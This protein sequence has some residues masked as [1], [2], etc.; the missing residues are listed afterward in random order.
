MSLFDPEFK[1]IS[2]KITYNKYGN[3]VSIIGG[4]QMY[5]QLRYDKQNR[6]SDYLYYFEPVGAVVVWHT[7]TYQPGNKI[8]DT[9]YSYTSSFVTD[10]IR[11]ESSTYS[12]KDTYYMDNAGRIIKYNS[13]NFIYNKSGNLIR[14]QDGDYA[15]EFKYD[16][17]INPWQTNKVLQFIY[18]DYS[19]NNSLKA[20]GFNQFGLPLKVVDNNLESGYSHPDIFEMY[21]WTELE[22]EYDCT[23]HENYE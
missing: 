2:F 3:P 8:I 14:R 23:G 20:T 5:I 1:H 17:K 18:K 11:P 16:D 21:T 7:Y 19:V 4:P 15:E 9:V 6:L 12:G 10:S 13:T 22:I